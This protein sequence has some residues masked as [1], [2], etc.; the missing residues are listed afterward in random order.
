MRPCCR[1]LMGYGYRSSSVFGSQGPKLN[2]SVADNLLKLQS[3]RPFSSCNGQVVGYIRAIDPNR[4][5]F[6][7]SDSD[8]GH[9]PRVYTSGVS[10]G[11]SVGNSS[12]RGVLVIPKVA[13]DFRNHS[14]SVESQVN[15]KSFENI[16]IQGGLNVKPLVIER[17]EKVHGDVVEEQESRVEVNGSNVNVNIGDS[18][19]LNDSKVEREL[20]EIEK[21]AWRLLQDS[22]VDYCGNPVGTLAAIDP[23]DKSPLNYDQVFIRDFVP[24]ALAF[25]LNGE[26]EIVKNFLLHTLQLQVMSCF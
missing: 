6:N 17:I 13:S 26:A 16:Y 8:W 24:S 23:A 21:E 22:V 15:G 7:A 9:Q 4:K 1:I 25:L 10:R 19:G 12:K 11:T 5:G 14:T 20:S 2:D 3:R 18:K